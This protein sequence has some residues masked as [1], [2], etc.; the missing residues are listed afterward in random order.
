MS[1]LAFAFLL[2][3]L[4]CSAPP[5]NEPEQAALTQRAADLAQQAIVVDTHIDIPYR[6]YEGVPED[7]TQRAARH[8]FDYVRAK[9][10]GLNAAFMSIFTPANF[11]DTGE[12]YD[13]ANALIDIVEGFERQW[14]EHFAIA[15]SVADV[16]EHFDRG[17]VSLPMGMENGAPVTDLAS[18]RHF[19]DR[20]VRYITLTHSRTNHIGDSFNEPRK[21]NGLSPF[22]E[23]VVTEM[24]RLG[25]M[26]DVSHVS[27]ETA[28][29]AIELTTAPPIA[30]H[31]SCRHFV[32]GFERNISDE[33]IR[34]LAA[35]GGVVNIN[36]ASF[37]ARADQYEKNGP[38]RAHLAD[39]M[40]QHGLARNTTKLREYE[41]QYRTE[42]GLYSDV[43]D[44]VDHIEHVIGLVGV[45]H[46][47]LGSD[48]DGLGSGLPEGLKDV[49][50]YPNIVYHLLERGHSEADIRKICGE[51]LLRV[52]ARVELRAAE[53]QQ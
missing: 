25:M 7:L 8:D 50:A 16:R 52:W 24:N 44:I 14:P 9:E 49:S 12:S 43:T 6:F 29:D 22:G 27:D 17:M 30:S 11:Q 3:S 20:G 5:S 2:F 46:V 34:Q 33:L 53:L 47:G 32:P 4:A 21:W 39:F 42:R 18:L 28:R 15:R 26:V 35:K 40:Q 45:N 1:R 41:T 19:H 23:E 51:N 13:V 36:F 48:F 31:S 38:V 10:G 37:F